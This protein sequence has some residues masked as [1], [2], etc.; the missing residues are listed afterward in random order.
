MENKRFDIIIPVGDKDVDFVSRVIDFVGRCL[1][2]YEYIYIITNERNI[3]KIKEKVRVYDYCIILDENKLLPGLNFANVRNLIYKYS[4]LNVNLTGWYF[5][6]FLKL[7][8]A[9]SPYSKE[10][11]LSWDAD[12]LPL[13]PISFFEEGHILFNPKHEKHENYFD[14]N[15]RLLGYGKIVEESF[16][17]ESMMFSS[18]IVKEL[19]NHIEQQ[20]I[21]GDSW[22]EKIICSCD[23]KKSPQ[24]FSE[25]ETY[26]NYC[27][28]Y[29][30]GLYKKRHLNTFR[31]AGL[32]RGRNISEN[33]LRKM[34]FDIDMASFEMLDMPG[35]PY[36]I[37][38]VFFK[39]KNKLKRV[40]LMTFKQIIDKITGEEAN[41]CNDDYYRLPHRLK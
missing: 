20:E 12:T 26:G 34:S 28:R 24:A 1:T 32:I 18:R 29:Y 33:L 41:N 4:S 36:N 19:L 23:F 11:Y 10:Y 21:P 16:I 40:K 37:P 30:P 22:M 7:G 13:A 3:K 8:F 14:T 31:E 39:I 2:S 27:Q 6:Q 35:F 9:L 17:S 15:F 5:Q 25:F 38:N